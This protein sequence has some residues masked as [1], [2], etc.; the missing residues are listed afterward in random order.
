MRTRKQM[1]RELRASMKENSVFLDNVEADIEAETPPVFRQWAN[2]LDE[3]RATLE[4][5]PFISSPFYPKILEGN[6]SMSR[7]NRRNSSWPRR[8]SG[9]KS[10][11]SGIPTEQASSSRSARCSAATSPTLRRCASH[12]A[13]L[14]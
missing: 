5:R 7:T 2:A 3:E 12:F 1:A 11:T 10:G 14:P 9:W 8:I 13:F 4:V 6:G